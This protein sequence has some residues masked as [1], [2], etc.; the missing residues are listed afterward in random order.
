VN[1]PLESLTSLLNKSV[2]KNDRYD[3][4]IKSPPRKQ[5]YCQ[6]NLPVWQKAISQG[7]VNPIF[8]RGVSFFGKWSIPLLAG[9]E[10][11]C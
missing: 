11:L 7:K 2:A 1:H 10:C 8:R 5:G 4:M 3:K 6:Y 9:K